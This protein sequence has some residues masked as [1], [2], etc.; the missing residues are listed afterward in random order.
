M[1]ILNSAQTHHRTRPIALIFLRP[2]NAGGAEIFHSLATLPTQYAH[3]QSYAAAS[4]ASH[5]AREAKG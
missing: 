4:L 1:S 5:L 3:V 2:Q